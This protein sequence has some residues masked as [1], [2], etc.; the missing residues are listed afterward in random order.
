MFLNGLGVL[1][2]ADLEDHFNADA[3]KRCEPDRALVI[4]LDNVSPCFRNVV[5]YR[6]EHSGPVQDQHL[7]NYVPSLS[8]EDLLKNAG[9]KISVDI[10]ARKDRAD[11]I[12]CTDLDLFRQQRCDSRGTSSLDDQVRVLHTMENALCYFFLGDLNHVVYIFPDQRQR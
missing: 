6:G 9:Q 2:I 4:N 10:S 3:A 5:Q 11:R 7:H 1:L 8:Y 12:T